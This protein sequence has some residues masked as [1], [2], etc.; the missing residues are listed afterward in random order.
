MSANET[1]GWTPGPWRVAPLSDYPDSTAINV[2]AGRR[3]YICEAGH[4]DNALAVANARLLASAPELAELAERVAEHFRDTDSPLGEA[5][6]AA[7]A[8]ARGSK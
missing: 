6:R 4:W 5:A 1:R 7:L 2:D 3:G 8:K